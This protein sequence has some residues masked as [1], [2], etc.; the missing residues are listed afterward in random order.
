MSRWAQWPPNPKTGWSA[1]LLD[2]RARF[3]RPEAQHTGLFRQ[4]LSQITAKALQRGEP[5]LWTHASL[6]AEPAFRKLGFTIGKREEVTIGQERFERFEK[7]PQLS[8]WTTGSG[9][10]FGASFRFRSVANVQWEGGLH[11]YLLVHRPANARR[12]AVLLFRLMQVIVRR[13]IAEDVRWFTFKVAADGGQ[14]PEADSL[15][16]A[17]F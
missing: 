11:P 8:E 6:M 9:M 13:V 2:R 10:D 1:Q 4:R 16:L 17:G 14:G 15:H 7:E 5:L 12:S 3:I